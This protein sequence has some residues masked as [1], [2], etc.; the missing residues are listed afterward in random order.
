MLKKIGFIFLVFMAG[1]VASI[2]LCYIKYGIPAH[3]D[4]G[5]IKFIFACFLAI[6]FGAVAVTKR[7]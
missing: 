7:T 1:S 5:W 6:V 3:Y 2:N 4:G